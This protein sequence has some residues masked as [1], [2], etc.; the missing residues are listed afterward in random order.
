VGL[1][2]ISDSSQTYFVPPSATSLE[3]RKRQIDEEDSGTSK[4]AEHE[5]EESSHETPL[6]FDPFEIAVELNS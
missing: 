5:A 1:T 2:H 4:L 6:A 3:G